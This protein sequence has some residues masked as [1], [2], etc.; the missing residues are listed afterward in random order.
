MKSTKNKIY[1]FDFDGVIANSIEVG[2]QVHNSISE[3]Y[4]LPK[5]ETQKD[6]LR[7]IDNGHL[8]DFLNYDIITEYYLESNLRYKS[9]LSK[10]KLF[11]AMKKI[12]QDLDENIIIISSNPDSFIGNILE[13]NEIDKVIIYGKEKA[14]SKKERFELLLKEQN[15]QK[16]DIIYIGDT[17][18]DY[19]FCREVNIPMVGSNYGYS[20]LSEISDS[21]LDI[22]ESPEEL[23]ELIKPYILVRR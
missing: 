19:H 20:D 4:D 1:V 22:K 5:I 7:I 9:N 23:V 14:K 16:C 10:I 18:D 15:I 3:K 8:K 13:N 12:L 17:I 11:P 6:Y 21:L 2:Y